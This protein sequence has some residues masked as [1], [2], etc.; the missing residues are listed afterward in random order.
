MDIK[1]IKNKIK[2]ENLNSLGSYSLIAEKIRDIIRR[3]E[4]DLS[5]KRVALISNFNIK[6]LADCLIVEAFRHDIFINVCEGEY[7]QWKQELLGDNLYNFKPDIIYVLT[8]DFGLDNDVLFEYHYRPQGEVRKKMEFHLED[9]FSLLEVV[10]KKTE[11][12][13]VIGNIPN[14]V[15]KILGVI[16]NKC[17]FNLSRILKEAN[18]KI[19]EEYFK[20]QQILVFDFDDWLNY[21]GKNQ[22]WYDKY[23]FL[24]DMRINPDALPF[25]AKELVSYLIPLAVKTKKCLVLDLDNTLWGGVIGEDGIG[26][27]SLAPHGKGHAFY[28]FQK[29][30]LALHKR[31]VIL[32]IN[33]KN[34]ISDVMKVFSKHPHMLLKEENFASIKVNWEDKVTNLKAIAEEINIGIDSLVFIDDDPAN[35]EMVKAFMPEVTVI[36]LPKE[37]ERYYKALF[38]YKGFNSLEFT[39]EDAERGKTYYT[40]KK[41]RDFKNESVDMDSFLG[42]LNIKVYIDLINDH[43]LARASQLTQKTNQFNLTTYRYSEEDLKDMLKQGAKIWTLGVEDRF[44][45]YGITGLA[46]VKKEEF[47]TIDTFLLSCRILGKKIEFEFLRYILEQLKKIDP[48]GLVRAKYVPTAKNIQVKDFYSKEGFRLVKGIDKDYDLLG[49]DLA[50]FFRKRSDLIEVK[51]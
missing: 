11:A 22:Y 28:V 46:I 21:M 9:L 25:L 10:K 7:A 35:R 8:D 50:G 14:N 31:G 33:S 47:W 17:S 26:G 24:G 15:H 34:N 23:Y 37:P 5:V 12:K 2:L 36:D 27:I 3:K 4:I 40:E 19:E 32:A 49:L 43:S 30:I 29:L 16:E 13:I 41:R 51:S 44:G 18:L 48:N 39:S 45:K 42:G 6:W 1:D 20:D 38:Q